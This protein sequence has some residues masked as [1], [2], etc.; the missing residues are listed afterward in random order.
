VRCE[1]D[2]LGQVDVAA[3]VAR[4][5]LVQGRLLSRANP[6]RRGRRG[7]FRVG[8]G[9]ASSRKSRTDQVKSVVIWMN[10]LRNASASSGMLD[11]SYL[12]ELR[13]SAARFP[14]KRATKPGADSGQAA[15]G[16][17]PASLRAQKKESE[18][19]SEQGGAARTLAERRC[20]LRS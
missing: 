9:K 20:S 16:T 19:A 5:S 8:E 14:K 18:G 11:G 10:S 1:R 13:M 7:Q 15:A 2:A 6:A 12:P 17:G 3:V 4:C